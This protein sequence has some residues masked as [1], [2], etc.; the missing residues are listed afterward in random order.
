MAED[1]DATHRFYVAIRNI[2]RGRSQ[3]PLAYWAHGRDDLDVTQMSVL[4]ALVERPEGLSIRAL[5]AAEQLDAGNASRTTAKLAESGLLCR[6]PSAA[7]GRSVVVKAT[8]AGIALGRKLI[9][10][11]DEFIGRVLGTFR[12]SDRAHVISILERIDLAFQ[13]FASSLVIDTPQ[14]RGRRMSRVVPRRISAR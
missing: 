10:R 13:E 8:T 14:E 7:D 1:L 11:R 2:R 5:A 6:E 4:M 9:Q 12:P 3:I